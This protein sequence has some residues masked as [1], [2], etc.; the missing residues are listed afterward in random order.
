MNLRPLTDSSVCSKVLPSNFCFNFLGEAT[1]RTQNC[2]TFPAFDS[3]ADDSSQNSKA[4]GL[5]KKYPAWKTKLAK[6]EPFCNQT[7][8]LFQANSNSLS[9]QNL[10][11]GEASKMKLMLE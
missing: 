3:S 7:M 11:V 6:V 9:K 10:G 5:E 4:T 1:T 2:P 8:F